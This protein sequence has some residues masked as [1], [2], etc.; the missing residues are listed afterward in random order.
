MGLNKDPTLDP[1]T[2]SCRRNRWT[3]HAQESELPMV[4]ANKNLLKA[5]RRLAI[6]DELLA[7]RLSGRL[8]VPQ[9]A[10]PKRCGGD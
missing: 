7:T 9:K 6:N 10:L 4:A 1:T 2:P 8:V 5:V 3:L